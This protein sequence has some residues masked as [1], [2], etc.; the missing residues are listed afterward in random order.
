MPI[1]SVSHPHQDTLDGVS[2]DNTNAMAAAKILRKKILMPTHFV[3]LNFF[4]CPF[5]TSKKFHKLWD[6]AVP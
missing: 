1:Q 5:C 4:Q 6:Q 2:R 3:L